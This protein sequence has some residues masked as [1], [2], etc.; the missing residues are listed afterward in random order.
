M[1]SQKNTEQLDYI[2]SQLSKSA[3]VFF[4]DYQGITHQALEELRRE[5]R[6]AS[7]EIKILKN[8]LTTIALKEDMKLDVGD[9]LEG[10]RAAL[11]CYEDPIAAAKVLKAFIK[12]NELPTIK[13]GVYQS[14]IID[15]AKVN[16]LAS[17]P[18]R[19]ELLGKIV[20]LLKS[21]I[22]SLIYDLN[23]PVMKLAFALKEI[24][25]K[26]QN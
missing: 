7:A 10:P 12:K 15:E 20:G 21:P 24:E 26:K 3:A 1:P 25:K 22:S 9:Q 2:K 8:T 13:F 11:F 6:N 17:L 16:E 23:Y 5:L 19:D 14:E 18:G 4:V